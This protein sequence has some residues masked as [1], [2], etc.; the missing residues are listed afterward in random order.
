LVLRG[1]GQNG[2]KNMQMILQSFRSDAA[3]KSHKPKEKPEQKNKSVPAPIKSLNVYLDN[4]VTL[5]H[6][7][8]DELKSFLAEHSTLAQ[9][10]PLAADDQRHLNDYYN[11]TDDLFR[12]VALE[13]GNQ[14][15]LETLCYDTYLLRKKKKFKEKNQG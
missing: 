6:Q 4:E 9:E 7:D 12:Q 15:P 1:K 5:I 14:I 10:H 13:T 2:V 11:S 3:M 8:L